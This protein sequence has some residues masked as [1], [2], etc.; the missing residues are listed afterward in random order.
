MV[1]ESGDLLFQ[2][3]Y[4]N[5]GLDDR[6]YRKLGACCPYTYLTKEDW[7]Q[8]LLDDNPFSYWSITVIRILGVITS[9]MV[10]EVHHKC[11]M[12]LKPLHMTGVLGQ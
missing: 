12:L 2:S 8:P 3:Y 6:H 5:N 9:N 4:I 1:I 11:P 7:T 10:E